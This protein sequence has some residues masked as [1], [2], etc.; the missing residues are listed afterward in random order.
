M[1]IKLIFKSL[2]I[3]AVLT[4]L[5]IMGLNNRDLVT[6]TMPNILPHPQRQPAAL[7]YIAFFGLG[8]LVG[9]VLMAGGGKKSGGSSGAKPSKAQA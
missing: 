8:F 9:A 2:V 6:L 3:I 4:M 7:M 1:N 5:V